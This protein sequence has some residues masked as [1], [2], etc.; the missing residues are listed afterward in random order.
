MYIARWGMGLRAGRGPTPWTIRRNRHRVQQAFPSIPLRSAFTMDS[1]YP[2]LSINSDSSLGPIAAQDRLTQDPPSTPATDRTQSVPVPF[3]SHSLGPAYSIPSSMR[4]SSLSNALGFNSHYNPRPNPANLVAP[5]PHFPSP[6]AHALATDPEQLYSPRFNSEHIQPPEVPEHFQSTITHGQPLHD[7]QPP[8]CSRP[9]EGS[10]PL[11]DFPPPT[12]SFQPPIER[13]SFPTGRNQPH[14]QP[15]ARHLQPHVD[16]FPPQLG[17]FPSGADHFQHSAAAFQSPAGP[18]TASVGSFPL[19]AG[20]SGYFP[21]PATAAGYFP[22]ISGSASY[23]PPPAGSASYFP[24]PAGYA[25]SSRLYRQ[26]SPAH[27]APPDLMHRPYPGAALAQD[28]LTEASASNPALPAPT[29]GKK[30]VRRAKSAQNVAD[31]AVREVL[32]AA[33]HYYLAAFMAEGPLFPDLAIKKRVAQEK[34]HQTRANMKK[35]GK[36]PPLVPSDLPSLNK[37]TL[38]R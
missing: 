5:I 30:T 28:A 37:V 25:G 32:E 12:T 15:L 36:R 33:G 27:T 24:P 21:P 14:I 19:P 35:M 9:L 34:I 6:I 10:W 29:K 20:S 22:P 31:Q 17:H 8:E 7:F 4:S 16:F 11:E 38:L 23:F 1:K 2:Y 3:Y 13:Y 26:V 18:S